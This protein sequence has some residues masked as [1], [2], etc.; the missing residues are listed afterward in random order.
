[1]VTWL[2]SRYIFRENEGV[3]FA[4]ETLHYKRVSRLKHSIF[5]T[6][7]I[8]SFFGKVC[9]P[10]LQI[11][12][13]IIWFKSW[14]TDT[15]SCCMFFQYKSKHESKIFHE[16]NSMNFWQNGTTQTQHCIYFDYGWIFQR[17]LYQYCF[18]LKSYDKYKYITN[19]FYLVLG[20][21]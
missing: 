13:Y 15:H 6:I 14:K 21:F 11:Y 4:Y 8:M 16:K 12:K 19:L 20:H 5:M 9:V 17:L 2:A 10:Q 3:M 7:F 18:I 1:M